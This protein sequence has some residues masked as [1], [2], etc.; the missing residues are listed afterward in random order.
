MSTDPA[1]PTTPA[2]R[3]ALEVA[4]RYHSPAMRDHCIRSY[5][6][7]AE[8]GRLRGYA[9]DDELLFV[10]ALLHDI[11]LTPEFDNVTLPFE[12]AG[13]HVAR[14]FAAGAGW[15]AERGDRAGEIIVHHMGEVP[16]PAVDPEGYLLSVATGLDISGRDAEWWPEELRRE[17]V[18]R[19][20]RGDLAAEFIGCLREQ[21]ERKPDSTAAAAV[22]SGIAGRMASNPLEAL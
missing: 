12:H 20:P 3:A 14:V 1:L 10:A 11:G 18:A 13:G 15:P 5:R 16:D 2:A 4:A 21:A 22:T 17:V 7:A 9:V 19:Y 8:L 6:W